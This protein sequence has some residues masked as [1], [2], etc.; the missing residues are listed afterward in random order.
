MRAFNINEEDILN[1]NLRNKI[2][3]FFRNY[4]ITIKYHQRREEDTN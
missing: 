3:K 2:R 1:S 4:D